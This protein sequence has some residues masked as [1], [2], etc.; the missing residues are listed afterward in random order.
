MIDEIAHTIER[1][2]SQLEALAVRGIRAA[3]PGDV[4][5]LRAAG[6]EFER[7]GAEHMT[8]RIGDVVRTLEQGDCPAAA[9]LLRAQT[10]LRLFERVLTLE[11]AQAALDALVEAK[12]AEEALVET[13]D[14]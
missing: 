14:A 9:A 3:G 12:S 2:R 4:A 7:V 5:L 10:S 11:I 1:L 8:E 6:E 13:Q